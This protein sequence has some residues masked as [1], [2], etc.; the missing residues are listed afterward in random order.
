M[1]KKDVILGVSIIVIALLL[2]IVMKFHN[3]SKGDEIRIKVNGRTYGTYSLDKN[4]EIDI[5]TEFGHNTVCIEDGEAYMKEADCPDGYCKHQGHISKGNQ[6]IVCLPHKLVVEIKI[7]ENQETNNDL[8][9]D[10]V[11]K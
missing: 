5:D 6:T 4:Q 2:M 7:N 10:A 11:A 1:K 3:N 8:I 9:P